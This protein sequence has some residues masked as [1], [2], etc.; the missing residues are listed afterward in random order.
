M[1]IGFVGYF[2][3]R[4]LG[5]FLGLVEGVFRGLFYVGGDSLGF[6]SRIRVFK[7]G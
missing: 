1:W 6:G 2:F 7:E 5:W 4:V 3:S